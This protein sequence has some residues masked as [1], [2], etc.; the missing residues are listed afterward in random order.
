MILRAG[1]RNWDKGGR[2]RLSSWWRGDLESMATADKMNECRWR[3]GSDLH[4]A[5]RF[6]GVED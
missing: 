4:Y 6:E 3:T 1:T 2:P 5:A